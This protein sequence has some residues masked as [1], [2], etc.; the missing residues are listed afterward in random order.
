MSKSLVVEITPVEG[1]EIRM[2][3]LEQMCVAQDG[4]GEENI[5]HAVK[6]PITRPC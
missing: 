5:G 4:I 6:D 1:Q 2:G 3:C